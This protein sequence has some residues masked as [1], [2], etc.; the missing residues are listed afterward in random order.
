MTDSGSSDTD[1]PRIPEI[2]YVCVHNAGRSQMAAALTRVLAGPRVRV[3]SAGSMPAKHVHP[4]VVEAMREIGVDLAD[5]LPQLLAAD[6]VRAADVV[7]S[8]GCGDACPV[9]PGT[10]YRDWKLPDPKGGALAHVR[11]TR[12]GIRRRVEELLCE[13]G[14]A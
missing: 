14:V 7:I 5:E 3:R 1:A 9:F 8:M 2:L 11:I 12:D 13:L 10:S 6:A 4:V